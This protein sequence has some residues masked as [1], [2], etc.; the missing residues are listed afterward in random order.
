MQCRYTFSHFHLL[1][2]LDS[3]NLQNPTK[4]LIEN[5]TQQRCGS[6]EFFCGDKSPTGCISKDWVCD[7]SID[8]SITEKDEE[9][10]KNFVCNPQQPNKCRTIN[11]CLEDVKLCDGFPDCPDKSD[12]DNCVKPE[13]ETVCDPYK[14]F[15]CARNNS[16]IEFNSVCNGID[17]CGDMSDERPGG[18]KDN[19]MKTPCKPNN[20][21]CEQVSYDL[22]L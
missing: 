12:E 9:N 8:C 14:Q 13:K 15:K 18:S 7:M 20:G 17:D 6:D 16:C 2:V 5:V 19:C 21:G 3:Q 11:K 22:Y 4:V 10:C 1:S